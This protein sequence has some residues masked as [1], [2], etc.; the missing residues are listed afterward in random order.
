MSPSAF[1]PF[2][3]FGGNMSAVGAHIY[4]FNVPV[5]TS[6]EAKILN[7]QLCYEIDLN[8]FASKANVHNELELGFNF[9]MDYNED[10]Q[11]T[12]NEN[13]I[14]EENAGLAS[15]FIESDKKNH[16]FIYLNTIG[17]NILTVQRTFDIL[18]HV[19]EKQCYRK[20]VYLCENR[21]HK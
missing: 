8:R 20:V 19:P 16:A 5:C 3:E 12:N 4:Q 9:I 18:Q 14:E 7:D 10:R 17:K 1:I 13:V 11:I 6:F 2:C 15:N 21:N